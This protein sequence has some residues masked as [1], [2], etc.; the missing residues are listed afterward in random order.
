[1][2]PA[3][4]LLPV[5]RHLHG[6]FCACGDCAP[7]DDHQH[8]D[9]LT[10]A[11]IEA[12]LTARLAAI[13]LP[14][15]MSALREAANRHLAPRDTRIVVLPHHNGGWITL[16]KQ[17]QADGTQVTSETPADCIGA[18]I[19]ETLARVVLWLDAPKGE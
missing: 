3:Y 9:E 10:D 14:Y 16:L 12:E 18:S 17:R 13:D 6:A 7:G 2:K 4:Q 19:E 1:M 5:H 11:A 8:E 15:E